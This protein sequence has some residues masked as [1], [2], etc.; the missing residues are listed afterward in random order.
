LLIMFGLILMIPIDLVDNDGNGYVD[1]INGW[2]FENEDNSVYDGL[3]DDHGTHV[4]GTIGAEGGNGQGVAGVNWDVG[5]ISGRFIGS[6]GFGFQSDAIEAINYM[7]DLKVNHGINIVATSNSWGSLG[8]SFNAALQ[9]AI[10]A[11]GDADILFIAAA[12]NN[13]A[14]TDATPFYPSGYTCAANSI[15]SGAYDCIISVAAIDSSG[16]LAGFSNY[17]ASTVD[18]GA[19]GVGIV[20]TV[21]SSTYSAYNGTSMATPHVSGAAALIAAI[22]P[23]YSA[24][25]IK[26][27]I[28]SNVAITASLADTVT[29][30]RLDLSFLASLPTPPPAGSVAVCHATETVGS[31]GPNYP[32]DAL[33]ISYSKVFVDRGSAAEAQHAAEDHDIM[34][35]SGVPGGDAPCPTPG[36]GLGTGGFVGFIRD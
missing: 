6:S 2:D 25:Q 15:P 19:P 8:G 22:N 21:P 10:E 3:F 7:T 20:S 30:G 27:A 32:G 12:G 34:W 29:G 9:A 13:G 28:L 35:L 33:F 23:A 24:T 11:G 16:Q 31:A 1:D 36:N 26:S 4:S 14:D 18:L 5:L 17:G